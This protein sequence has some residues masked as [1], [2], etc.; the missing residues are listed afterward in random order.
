M[1]SGEAEMYVCENEI[2]KGS[3]EE[4]KFYPVKSR[5][6]VVWIRKDHQAHQEERFLRAKFLEEPQEERS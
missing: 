6:R 5:L 1:I 2:S 4:I 3:E